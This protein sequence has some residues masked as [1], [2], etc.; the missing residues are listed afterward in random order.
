MKKQKQEK[1]LYF[2]IGKL[3]GKMCKKKP[4]NTKAYSELMVK[5]IN[6]LIEFKIQEKE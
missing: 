4:K 3:V 2:E 5:I 1:D 6:L